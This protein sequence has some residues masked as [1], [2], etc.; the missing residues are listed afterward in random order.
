MLL[1]SIISV[2]SRIDKK[3]TENSEWIFKE[4]EETYSVSPAPYFDQLVGYIGALDEWSIFKRR[5]K[6]KPDK[7]EYIYFEHS[8]M[9][10]HLGLQFILTGILSVFYDPTRSNVN[11][12]GF[13]AFPSGRD[14][15]KFLGEI[16]ISGIRK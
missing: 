3:K 12:P 8:D 2:K 13:T 11:R 5:P 7:A 15:D 10:S 6:N 14:R 4:L 16:E 9:E 1:L